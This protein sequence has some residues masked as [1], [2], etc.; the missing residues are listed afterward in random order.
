MSQGNE[1]DKTLRFDQSFHNDKDSNSTDYVIKILYVYHIS[2]INITTKVK[3]QQVQN[4]YNIKELLPVD[5]C[6]SK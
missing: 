2:S 6:H 1:S 3:C 4:I 5:K